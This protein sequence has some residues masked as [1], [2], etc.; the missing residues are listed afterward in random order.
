MAFAFLG[1]LLRPPQLSGIEV[2]ELEVEKGIAKFDLQLEIEEEGDSLVGF[3]EYNVDL[4][5]DDTIFRLL[6][7]LRNLLAGIVANPDRRICEFPLLIEPERQ[8]LLV[9]WN[10]TASQYFQ[11]KCIHELFE[12]QVEKSPDS[13][14]VVFEDQQVTYRELNIRANQLAHHLLSSAS[15]RRRW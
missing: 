8:K 14:A 15:G 1:T 6:E 10:D 5:N 3:V 13:I 7:H 4:F 2:S 12:D 9:E 11:D